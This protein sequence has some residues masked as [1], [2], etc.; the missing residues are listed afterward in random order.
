MALINKEGYYYLCS[1]EGEP[2]SDYRQNDPHLYSY[3]DFDDG[4]DYYYIEIKDAEAF[5][6]F[7]LRSLLEW[8]LILKIR[9]LNDPTH[10]VICNSHEA[11]DSIVE[12]I[13]K[14]VV[15]SHH[16]PAEKI[17]VFSGSFDL[18]STIED[19]SEKFRR[20]K[21]K[22]ELVMDFEKAVQETVEHFEHVNGREF[23]IPQ[24]LDYK[25]YPKKY[26]NFN[27]RWRPARPTFVS[28]LLAYGILDQGYVS[29]APS[30]C[31]S[32]WPEYWMNIEHMNHE[33]T[34]LLEIIRPHRGEIINLPPLYLDTDDLVTNRAVAD[35]STSYL[36]ENTYFSLVAETNY[37]TSH[38][39]MESSR[40]LSEKAFKP[41]LFKHPFI[42]ISTPRILSAIKQ[43]GYQTF[44]PLINE[45]YDWIDNDGDRMIAIVEE[46]KR[47]CSLNHKELKEFLGGCKEI[48]DFNYDVFMMKKKFT[49]KL[50]Y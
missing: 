40:F 32:K 16:I 47:L 22:A 19:A 18:A 28:L 24:T 1:T 43:I 27:R 49:H 12:P 29:L 21:L 4:M 50:N 8:D 15:L 42:F 46:T 45:S 5:K 37:Y 34:Q 44:S 31:G 7:P 11:F 20:G 41:M 23:K 9:D 17:I 33:F 26:I 6:Y 39:G 14:Y 2:Y 3:R 30:D 10:L 13:Y 25:D 35:D 36:Y 48:C 38:S